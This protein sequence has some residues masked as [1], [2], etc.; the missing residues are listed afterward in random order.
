VAL[1]VA[2]GL[3]VAVIASVTPVGKLE[4]MVNI[5]TLT[6][7]MLVSLA[8]PVLRR[9]RGDLE[10]SF[11]VPWSPWLPWLSALICVFL[12][13]NLTVETWLR[14]L[15]WMAL[16]FGIY[17]FYGYGHSRVGKGEGVPAHDYTR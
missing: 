9:T 11:R 10:R 5:G 7:F 8:V 13:V 4:E 6:A 12:M 1:T 17:F 16:G 14:F 3:V 2:I 15:V